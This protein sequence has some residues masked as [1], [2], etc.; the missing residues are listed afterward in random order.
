MMDAVVAQG[1]DVR[2]D[3]RRQRS[4]AQRVSGF[5]DLQF[6]ETPATIADQWRSGW[7]RAA[8]A[9]SSSFRIFRAVDDSVDHLVAELHRRDLLR[10]E[11]EGKT[12]RGN[13]RPS[14]RENRFF[15]A[16]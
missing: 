12:L 4:S 14:S 10:R 9:S 8:G 2:P 1:T 13:S 11:Y 6:I 15:S 16:R 5:S 3:R 7:S